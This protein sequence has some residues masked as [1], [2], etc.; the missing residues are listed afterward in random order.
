MPNLRQLSR[1][2]LLLA[3]FGAGA[4]VFAAEELDLRRVGSWQDGQVGSIDSMTLEGDRLYVGRSPNGRLTKAGLFILDVSH[5]QAPKTLGHFSSMGSAGGIAI[6]GTTAY[7]CNGT[8]G[9]WVLDVAD[10]QKPQVVGQ[11][12]GATNCN[13]IVARGQQ[14]YLADTFQ[15]LL[16]LD[17]TNPANPVKVGE[18]ATGDGALDVVVA[19]DFAFLASKS[20]GISVVNVHNPISPLLVTNL[21][22]GT[23]Q[24]RSVAIADNTLYAAFSGGSSI[25]GVFDV[26][27]PTKPV[28]VT[29]V[30][31]VIGLRVAQAGGRVGMT[32]T[33]VSDSFSAFSANTPHKPVL[34]GQFPFPLF[35]VGLALA[36]NQQHAFVA[37]E[38]PGQASTIEVLAIHEP[39]APV[40]GG[41]VP[42][43]KPGVAIREVFASASGAVHVV[44]GDDSMT[45]FNT[46][47]PFT[48]EPTHTNT[49][50]GL[51][52]GVFSGMEFDGDLGLAW[53]GPYGPWTLDLS[54]PLSPKILGEFPVEANGWQFVIG[55]TRSFGNGGNRLYRLDLSDL[56][57]P[58]LTGHLTN[59]VN[60]Q[61][62]AL[63]GNRLY[64][65]TQTPTLQV[66]DVSVPETFTLL[67]SQ[68][69][70]GRPREMVVSDQHL[71]LLQSER[72]SVAAYSLA[73]PA[74]PVLVGTY[75]ND[76]QFDEA[77]FIAMLLYDD[78]LYCQVW[79][80]GFEVLDVSQPDN[81]RRVG[82]NSL[83]V[84]SIATDGQALYAT[85]AVGMRGMRIYPLLQREPFRLQNPHSNNG[86]VSFEVRGIVGRTASLERAVTLGDWKPWRSV[87]LTSGTLTVEDDT[88]D[89]TAFYRIV[90]P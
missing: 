31:G 81:I 87:S 53:S 75:T 30:P 29:N 20:Q 79:N 67:S 90:V 48:P 27:D 14:V 37:A 19:G 77:S 39:A 74:A 71:Y 26:S 62:L 78:F 2:L 80:G 21:F 36:M 4:I 55:G 22:L 24:T 64:V 83:P 44:R 68:P 60:F 51:G 46:A 65:G 85:T 13:G 76:T 84:R 18:L 50:K 89:T 23:R 73:V 47:S 82:G 69:T 8:N 17:V 10:P 15:G 45:T 41:F 52:G 12:T 72:R 3:A 59:S 42:F 16:I 34:A 58:K 32:T 57:M 63:F 38:E 1:A 40:S 43:D 88:T 86:R 70:I 49:L 5:S 54:A 11:F 9:V 28:L 33:G 6:S 66:F 7:F 61:A 25:M 35:T 56:T